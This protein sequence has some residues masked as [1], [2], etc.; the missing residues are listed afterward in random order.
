M[1]YYIH[2]MFE[3]LKFIFQDLGHT[4][5]TFIVVNLLQIQLNQD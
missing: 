2:Q 4:K 3:K 1:T 5:Q